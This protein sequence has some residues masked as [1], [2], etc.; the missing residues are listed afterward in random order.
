M[1]TLNVYDIEGKVKN[2]VA[3]GNIPDDFKPDEVLIVRSLRRQMSN[4]RKP[5]AHVK[6]RGEVRGG[7]RKP[8]RQKGTGRSRQG[9]IRAVQWRGGNVA[10]GPQTNR[11]FSVAMNKKERRVAL[12]HLIWAQITEGD[13]LLFDDLDFDQPSTRKAKAFLQSLNREG[14]FLLV[15]PKDED[16]ENVRKSF[17]NLSTVSILPPERLNTYDLLRN[18]TVLVHKDAFETVRS[19]WQV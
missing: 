10:F 7:G 17:R 18:D 19:T 1:A 5:F 16:F 6:N 14:R 15:V 2:E 12:R 13:W 4:A 11:N 3:L 8:W 9:T